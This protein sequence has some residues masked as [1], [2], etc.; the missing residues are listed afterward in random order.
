MDEAESRHHYESFVDSFVIPRKRERWK[1]LFGHASANLFR[2]SHKFRADL[3]VSL[4]E[5][6]LPDSIAMAGQT[7]IYF[8]FRGPGVA[9]DIREAMRRG[10]SNDAIYS[11]VPGKL[12]LFFFHEGEILLCSK[13]AR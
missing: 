1:Y 7:G 5:P 9:L 11:M 10:N 6:F 3:L 4:T 12:G 2:Q 13:Q 8:D